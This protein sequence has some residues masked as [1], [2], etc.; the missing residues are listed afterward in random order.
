M[1]REAVPVEAIVVGDRRREDLGDIAALAASISRHGL[2]HPIVVDEQTRLVAGGRRLAAAKQL[3][4]ARIEI[5][6]LGD[7]T[8]TELREIELEENVRRKD[9]TE[10]ERSRQM[11][12]LA[13]VAAE[14]DRAEFRAPDAHNPGRPEQPGSRRLWKTA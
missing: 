13:Q 9:L 11:V 6:R 7:L 8:D 3:G 12:A 2:L 5:R 4:W 10:Y 14:I 1:T